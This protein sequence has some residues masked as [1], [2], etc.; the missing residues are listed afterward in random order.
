M[1]SSIGEIAKLVR[2]PDL[3]QGTVRRRLR[4]LSEVIASTMRG[5]DGS[6]LSLFD[7]ATWNECRELSHPNP[8][9]SGN[10]MPK[11]LVDAI[12][13]HVGGGD[14]LKAI[15]EHIRTAQFS[16]RIWMFVW[17]DDPTGNEVA[18][19]VLDAAERGVKV[20]IH[21]DQCGVM[22]ER[23]TGTAQ[24]FFHKGLVR[25]RDL[26]G[27]SL[28]R[29]AYS[30]GM[31]KYIRQ[32]PNV[33]A[34]RLMEHPNVTIESRARYDHSKVYIFDNE[35]IILGGVNISDTSRHEF[36]DYMVQ[37]QSKLLVG[38][39]LSRLEGREMGDIPLGAS[40]D[41][42]FNVIKSRRDRKRE[43]VTVMQHL[44]ESAQ[45]E[46]II[47]MAYFGDRRLTD[48]IVA[49]AQR[50]VQVAVITSERSDVQHDLN[51]KILR[52]ILKRSPADTIRIYLSRAT[53][54]KVI[55]VDR[56][57]TFLGSANMNT[58]GTVKL[59]EAN[60]FVNDGDGV[61][62]HSPQSPFTKEL[63]AQ[64]LADMQA[65]KRVVSPH[66]LKVKKLRAWLESR[67]AS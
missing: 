39:F 17:C 57:R 33:L 30:A 3:P 45:R 62:P 14:S 37:L 31:K 25:I 59:G 12:T 66:Q 23:G 32:Q 21:K 2:S 27:V 18:S 51:Y 60:I 5:V 42:F 26:V 47:Q 61:S 10:R 43:V 58:T 65:S 35:T 29:W 41:F 11:R 9:V 22:F 40:V 34:D 53:H 46:V 56:S 24:S 63:R 19:A 36:H 52:D 6:L 49:A 20:V 55:H 28:M 48:A 4:H 54:A 38:R 44:L 1:Y 50:G 67:I 15:L 16:I 8:L 64:L 7:N 13:L